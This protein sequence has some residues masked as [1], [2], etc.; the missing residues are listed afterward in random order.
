MAKKKVVIISAPSGAGKT[1]M[2]KHLLSNFPQLEFSVSACSRPKRPNEIDGVDYFFLTVEEFKQRI[3]NNEFIEWQEVYPNRFYGT[4]KA[5]VERIWAKNHVVLFDVDV[6]GG[7]NLKKIFKDEAV[8][9]FIAPPSID[10]LKERLEKRGTENIESLKQRVEK[11][12]Y[13]MKFQSQFDY[14]VVND[15][16]ELAIQEIT[17]IVLTHI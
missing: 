16:L 4:L 14:V 3:K 17:S 15:N 5:E 8:S 10:V 2:V 1:T 7:I 9:I 13:E 11:A 12:E 6:L